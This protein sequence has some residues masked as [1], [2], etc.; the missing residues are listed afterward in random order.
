MVPL[1][2]GRIRVEAF[3]ALQ[4]DEFRLQ[5]R[6]EGA[7]D[8]GLA[9]ARLSFD[10]EGL[11]HPDGEEDG[12]PDRAVGDVL[13]PLK[14][15]EDLVDS[16][17]ASFLRHDLPSGSIDGTA[18]AVFNV[19]P[20]G[21][22]LREATDAGIRGHS[23]DPGG[24]FLDPLRSAEGPRGGR[25]QAPGA[26][27]VRGGLALRRPGGR[28]PRPRLDGTCRGAVYFGGRG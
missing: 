23:P 8:L 20:S 9:A 21:R 10:E 24:R 6:R 1:V 25:G 22:L 7:S 15:F 2:Q 11:A 14:A 13:L 19:W 5:G 28:F 18:V 27:C 17:D 26:A 3:I 16:V 4:A 12:H